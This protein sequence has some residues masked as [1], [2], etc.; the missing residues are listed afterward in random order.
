MPD[1]R[2]H[3]RT[4]AIGYCS[5]CASFG[6]GRCLH[7]GTDGKWYCLPCAREHS[8]VLSD[9]S[10]DPHPE[11]SV[12]LKL[13]ACYRDGRTLSGT[14]YNLVPNRDTFHLVTVSG[15]R[16]LVKFS[17]LKYVKQVSDFS[18]SP[19]A[20]RAD[21]RLPKH[22]RGQEIEIHFADGEILKAY[23]K[24]QYHP[25]APRFRVMPVS[26]P[27]QVSILVER[28]AT[29]DVAVGDQLAQQNLSDLISDPLRQSLLKFYR[30]N[31]S[32]ITP[33]ETLAQRF[34]IRTTQLET[35]LKPFYLLK[36]IRKIS[37]A[38]GEHLEFLPPPNRKVHAFLRE[39]APKKRR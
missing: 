7:R 25:D 38:R 17:D 39:H 23:F 24:G 30:Q 28:S 34:H 12:H 5:L 3:P 21:R 4:E 1:C 32:L 8:V 6:C 16:L 31:S 37:T 10:E 2:F 36:L 20:R 27:D 14:S 26:G 15:E 35:A 18:P 22:M 9:R 29:T 33:I 13:E 11:K 19:T